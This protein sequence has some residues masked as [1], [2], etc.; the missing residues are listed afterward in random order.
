MQNWDTFATDMEK[1]AWQKYDLDE[2]KRLS[3]QEELN[4]LYDQRNGVADR[5]LTQ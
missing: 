2:Y 5:L 1:R 3:A 4:E